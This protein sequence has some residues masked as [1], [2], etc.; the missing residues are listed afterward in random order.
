MTGAGRMIGTTGLGEETMTVAMAMVA[1]MTILCRGEMI[2]K[3][4]GMTAIAAET[5]MT[6]VTDGAETTRTIVT[7]VVGTTIRRPGRTTGTGAGETRILLLEQMT[8]IGGAETRRIAVAEMRTI[9]VAETRTIGVAE[10]MT[11]A[12]AETTT[13]LA[14]AA[15]TT[16]GV[17]EKTLA[18]RDE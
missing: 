16:I 2:A 17:A 6:I 7:D 11:I 12:T 18:R 15:T 3:G 13:M 10:T 1:E 8:A 4:A 9:G 5:T 14:G